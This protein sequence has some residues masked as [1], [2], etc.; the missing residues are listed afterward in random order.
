M[1]YHAARIAYKAGA[2][3]E[4]ARTIGAQLALEK[5]YSLERAQELLCK[6]RENLNG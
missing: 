2:R 3:G 1:K 6:L 5:N 4:E